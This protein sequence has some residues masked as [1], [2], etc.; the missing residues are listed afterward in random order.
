[1]ENTTQLP[2]LVKGYN[3]DL[4]GSNSSLPSTGAAVLWNNVFDSGRGDVVA[5][6]AIQTGAY[7][8]F[9]R[10]TGALV[11]I[12]VAGIQ[13]ISGINADD[14]APIANPG[15]YFITPIKQPGGQTLSLNLGTS[16]GN[17]GLQVLAFYE[18]KFATPEMKQKLIYARLKRKYQAFYQTVTVNAAN[19]TSQ[20]FT[21]PQSQG[22]VVGVE[23]VAYLNSTANLTDLG[24]S[25]INISVNGTTI[26][27]NLLCA[28]GANHSTRPQLWPI[29][30]K[31]GNTLSF[32]VNASNA[33][34]APNFTVGL[35][36]YFDASND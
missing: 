14:F 3:S 12:S 26:I 32:N 1:M 7:Q 23:F 11:T 15:N 2:L 21:I 5:L 28:Y 13:V 16:S 4:N 25:T 31:G 8:F 24:T 22:N 34:A 33:L 19:Q 18:N 30:I 9:G 36:L 20:Q 29:F 10:N 35:K 27:E 17:N 6:D